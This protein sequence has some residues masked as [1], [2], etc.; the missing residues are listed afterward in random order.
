[1]VRIKIR[2][3]GHKHNYKNISPGLFRRVIK[4]YKT[5]DLR[6]QIE[7]DLLEEQ[8]NVVEMNE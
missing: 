5:K 7:L 8:L 1:M 3:R 4:R 2:R 6:D